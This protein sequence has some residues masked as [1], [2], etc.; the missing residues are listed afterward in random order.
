MSIIRKLKHKLMLDSRS[1]KLNL[2]LDQVCKSD[3][4]TVLDVGAADIEYSP[5]DNFLE[6]NYPYPNKI[7]ALSIFPLV[8][9]T[10]RYPDVSTVVFSGG[11]FPFDDNSFD[12]VHSNAVIEHVGGRELQVNF[13][14]ELSRVGKRFFF[15]TPAKHFLVETHTNV[16]IFHLLPKRLFDGILR[17]IGKGWATG[18]YMNLLSKHDIEVILRLAGVPKFRI[19]TNRMFGLPLHYIVVGEK[20]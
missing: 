19:I 2:F 20:E 15:T 12:V 11:A 3:D 7:T 5:F 1:S 4:D 18:D 8:H 14:K 17:I 6:K 10:K 13:V 16:P 9:F